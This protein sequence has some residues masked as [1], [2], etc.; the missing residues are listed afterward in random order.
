M[1]RVCIP[2]SQVVA[3]LTERWNHMTH[4]ERWALVALLKILQ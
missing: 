1:G 2:L 3:L 4:E